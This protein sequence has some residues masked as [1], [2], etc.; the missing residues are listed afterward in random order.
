MKLAAVEQP[1]KDVGDLGFDDT[2][3]VVLDPHQESILSGLFDPDFQLREDVSF[4]AG[5][6]GIV[7][8]F[9]DGGEQGLAGV[10][11]TEEVAILGEEFADADGPLVVGHL[12]GL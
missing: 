6:E 8:G 11:K 1:A 10:V 3:A 5:V 9:L 2:G 12:F 7:H 4:F